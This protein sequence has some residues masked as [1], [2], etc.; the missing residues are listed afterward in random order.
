MSGIRQ[1]AAGQNAWVASIDDLAMGRKRRFSAHPATRFDRGDGPTASDPAPEAER[2]TRAI[3]AEIIPR[4]MLA[5]RSAARHDAGATPA[6][7]APTPEDAAELARLSIAHDLSLART[8]VESL[9]SDGVVLDE[10]VLDVLAPAARLLGDLWMRD[11]CRFTDVTVGLCRLQQLARELGPDFERPS[12]SMRASPRI[13]LAPAPGEQ[14]VFGLIVLEHFLRRDGWD[15]WAGSKNVDRRLA[16]L[17]KREW[18]GAVGLTISTESLLEP[19]KG[20]V[21]EL[22]HAAANP[23]MLVLVGGACGEHVGDLAER[24]GA[25]AAPGDVHDTLTFLNGQLRPADGERAR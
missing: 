13:V 20:H 21:A 18:I 12:S 14:H 11:L 7:R 9:R 19:L 10:I 23:D 25:D 15:V 3:E 5:H 17:V 8:F 24:A 1:N 6:P 2:L 22:R 16:R 4:L